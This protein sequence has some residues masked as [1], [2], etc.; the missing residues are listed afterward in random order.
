MKSWAFVLISL[1]GACSGSFFGPPPPFPPKGMYALVSTQQNGGERRS[2]K[3]LELGGREQFE[4]FVSKLLDKN[5]KRTGF[6]V[7]NG[8]FAIEG[9]C[10]TPDGDLRGL[11]VKFTGTWTENSIDVDNEITLMG[12]TIRGHGTYSFLYAAD[13]EYSARKSGN[14]PAAQR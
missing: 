5:C 6:E 12:A 13:D 9:T 4:M 14:R 2:E 8:T 7:K 3:F 11:P 10:D 1:T